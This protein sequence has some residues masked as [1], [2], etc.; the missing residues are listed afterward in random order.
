MAA[1][2]TSEASGE[3]ETNK[4]SD[5]PSRQT[6]FWYG[7]GPVEFMSLFLRLTDMRGDEKA[8]SISSATLAHP[9]AC[10]EARE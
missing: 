8:L 1:V 2:E 5:V 4:T 6:N 9:D 3:Q 10:S 7:I